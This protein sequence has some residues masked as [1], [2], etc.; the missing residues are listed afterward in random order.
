MKSDIIVKLQMAQIGSFLRLSLSLLLTLQGYIYQS[1]IVIVNL[2][3]FSGLRLAEITKNEQ[4]EQELPE[5][6]ITTRLLNFKNFHV[7]RFCGVFL[8]FF[9]VFLCTCKRVW[10]VFFFIT[11]HAVCTSGYF[12]RLCIT[13]LLNRSSSSCCRTNRQSGQKRRQ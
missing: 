10:V 11:R 1:L 2:L 13:F 7:V 3:T 4:E 12:T 6:E 9:I 5:I 8:F